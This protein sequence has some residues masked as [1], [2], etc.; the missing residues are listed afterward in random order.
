MKL[1]KSVRLDDSDERIFA[2]EGGAAGDGEWMVSGGYAVCG[3]TEGH[4][5][6]QCHCLTTFVA[7][8]SCRRSTIAEVAEIDAASYERLTEALARHFVE[9]LG[10]PSLAAARAAAEDEMRYTADL[11]A[12]FPDD[13][14]ITVRREVTADGL[15]ERYSVYNRLMI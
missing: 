13:V 14:W 11:A 1:L 15:S 7:V 5:I 4:R 6:P 2:A 10:A 3:L 12:G 8:G 9:T